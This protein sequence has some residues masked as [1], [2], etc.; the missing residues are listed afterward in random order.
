MTS[1]KEMLLQTHAES[2]LQSD[3]KGEKPLEVSWEPSWFF[4]ILFTLCIYILKKF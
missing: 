1:F 2:E 3:A 4:N